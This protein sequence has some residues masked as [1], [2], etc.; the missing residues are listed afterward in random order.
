MEARRWRT[1]LAAAL[2]L[3]ATLGLLL[4]GKSQLGLAAEENLEGWLQG[5]RGSPWAF[6]ATVA[7]FVLSAFIG[8][9]P[10]HPHCRLCGRVR[11]VA[12]FLL[13][14]GGDGGLGRA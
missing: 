11:A 6:A 4:L 3:G 2:L 13:Q 12:G 1:A 7:L 14:L 9:P 10:V 5:Y 8:A